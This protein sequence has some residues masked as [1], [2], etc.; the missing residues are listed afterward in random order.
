[1]T[2]D[3]LRENYTDE[4]SL[5]EMT[6]KAIEVLNRKNSNGYI[7]MVEG[8]K[9]DHAHHQN[10]A[11]LALHEVV[12]LD[13]AVEAALKMISDDTLVIV[14]ADHSHALTFNGYP[15]R[16]NDILGFGNKNE[17]TLPY[18]TISYANGPGFG[19]HRADKNAVAETVY[20]TWKK[21]ETMDRSSPVYRHIATLPLGDETHG[22]T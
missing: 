4:P 6:V 9:I 19:E 20:D 15:K 10:F 3:Y 8:G 2:Y 14:T 18:E 7:L 16:G 22:G 1:M 12:G 13:K 11:K 21:V 5:A 17:A